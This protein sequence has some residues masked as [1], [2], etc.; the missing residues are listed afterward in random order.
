LGIFFPEKFLKIERKYTVKVSL[1]R[2]SMSASC[3]LDGSWQ[4]GQG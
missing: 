1:I 3:V 4:M 2:K